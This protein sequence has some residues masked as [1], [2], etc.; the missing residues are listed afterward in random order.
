MERS[1]VIPAETTLNLPTPI[2]PPGDH[3]GI[4]EPKQDQLILAQ[5]TEPIKLGLPTCHPTK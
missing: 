1:P 3:I 4:H 2:N 5:T